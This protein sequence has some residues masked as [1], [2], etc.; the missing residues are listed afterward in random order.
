MRFCSFGDA[1]L[2]DQ[3]QKL[4]HL[5]KG[6]VDVKDLEVIYGVVVKPEDGME[7]SMMGLGPEVD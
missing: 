2:I 4:P 7:S 1:E 6:F 5:K 3:P